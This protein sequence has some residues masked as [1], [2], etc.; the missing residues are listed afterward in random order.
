MTV[1][2]NSIVELYVIYFNRAPDPAG[3][4]FWS[5]QDITIEE[6]AAQFGAS[7]EAK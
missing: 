5:A 2:Q 1:A 3:L 6:M 7:P 4:Q